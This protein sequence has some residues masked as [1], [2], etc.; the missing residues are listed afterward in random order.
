MPLLLRILV[1]LLTPSLSPCIKPTSPHPPPKV[2]RDR[3]TQPNCIGG[4]R[5]PG[6]ARTPPRPYAARHGYGTAPGHSRASRVGIRARSTQRVISKVK[7][8][9]VKRDYTYVRRDCRSLHLVQRLSDY[10]KVGDVRS[11]WVQ[12]PFTLGALRKRID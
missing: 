8:K 6:R 4:T 11:V 1:Q 5:V 7:R 12:S 9:N 10:F 2:P 3:P